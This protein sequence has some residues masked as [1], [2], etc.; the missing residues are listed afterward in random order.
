MN[1]TNEKPAVPGTW[2]WRAAGSNIITALVFVHQR[3]TDDLPGGPLKG[4]VLHGAK[5]YDGHLIT[6]WA[7]EWFGPIPF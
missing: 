5:F 4:M 3:L 6:S 1:W 2:L 7:G